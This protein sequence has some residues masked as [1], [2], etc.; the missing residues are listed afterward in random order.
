MA[1]NPRPPA[2]RILVVDDDPGVLA[3]VQ[4]VLS[5]LPVQEIVAVERGDR[6]VSLLGREA[7][8]L[9]LVDLRLPEVDGLGVLAASREA[10]P[11]CPVVMFTGDPTVETAVQAL[12]QGAADYL[13]KPLGAGALLAVSERLLEA[14]RLRREHR[15]LRRR[16]D[17]PPEFRKIVGDSPAIH[18][19]IDLAARLATSDVDVLIVGETGTGKELVARSIHRRSTR[20]DGPFVPVDCGAI[21]GDLLEREFFGHVKGAF[22]GAE[23]RGIGLLEYAHGGVLFLDEVTSLAPPLQAKLLRTLQ[24]RAFRRLGSVREIRVDVRVISA[25]NRD[26]GELVRAGKFRQD[27]YYRLNVARVQVPP[28]RE[29]REDIR[30]LALHFLEL[31][32]PGLSFSEETLEVLAAYPWPGNVRELENVVRR[33]AAVAAGNRLEPEDLPDEILSEAGYRDRVPPRG[34]LD[35]REAHV[36]A[37]ERDYLTRLLRRTGGDV[38]RAAREAG[39]PRGSLYRLLKRHGLLPSA[40]RKGGAGPSGDPVTPA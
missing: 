8:D 9:V 2:A 6:A 39:L 19:T 16:L 23:A 20:K 15:L 5:S 28:L 24:E 1:P 22:T 31:V 36:A 30:P 33:M 26:P 14:G 29:R 35:L 32:D 17:R 18:R 4:D 40:F 25:A 37:F 7:F 12:K 13:V 38:S 3:F 27:L 21:P 11:D 34:F 10:D